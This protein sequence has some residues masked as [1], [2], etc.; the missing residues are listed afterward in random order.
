[1]RVMAQLSRNTS[2]RHQDLLALADRM[3]EGLVACDPEQ[4]ILYGS[5]AR[6]K[7]DQYSDVDLLVVKET[8]QGYWER[9]AEVLEFLPKRP[10][11]ESIGDVD[12]KVYTPAQFERAIR[13]G[14]PFLESVLGD[15][16]V[17][18]DKKSGV[19]PRR[20]GA[21]HQVVMGWR[22]TIREAAVTCGTQLAKTSRSE[23]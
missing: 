7:A 14:S 16:K 18:Y 11:G 6:G 15:G 10:P 12:L 3:V 19:Q 4:I 9:L 5:L 21:T 20:R 13:V 8:E 22:D 23:P 17:V 2:Q 1:M